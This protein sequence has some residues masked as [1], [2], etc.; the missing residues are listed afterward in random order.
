MTKNF[1][2]VVEGET[3]KLF[4]TEYLKHINL[5]SSVPEVIKNLGGIDKLAGH[6]QK[7]QE[8]LN[9]GVKILLILDANSNPK[10]RRKSIEGIIN[11][12]INGQ[13]LPLFL[14][15]DN[16]S[17]GD[18]ENL[19]EQIILREHAGIFECFE[20]Y[21]RCLKDKNNGYIPP[22]MKGKIYAYT[23][24]LDAKG[25]S[26]QYRPEYWDFHHPSLNPLKKFLTEKTR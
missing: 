5:S 10:R 12:K 1:H 21:E 23:E 24:A 6:T 17:N 11:T 8:H 20:N 9:D 16:H 25:K 3:D 7:M 14:F 22:D 4:M 15:P 2:I 18:L 19:L 26:N 13:N